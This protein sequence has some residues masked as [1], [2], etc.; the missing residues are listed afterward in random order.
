MLKAVGFLIGN[1]LAAWVLA[2]VLGSHL[3]YPPEIPVRF[4]PVLPALVLATVF[5]LLGLPVAA[6][7]ARFRGPVILLTMPVSIAAAGAYCLPFDRSGGALMALVIAQNSPLV[8]L[9]GAGW[10]LVWS[11]VTFPPVKPAP[12]RPA[13]PPREELPV[14]DQWS[15]SE[16]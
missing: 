5:S 1:L 11:F 6:L 7:K 10:G 4:Q 8:S 3:Q 16:R 9:A 13:A 12:P 14:S 2:Q 15:G